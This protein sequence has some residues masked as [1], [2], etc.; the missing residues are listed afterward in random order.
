[1]VELNLL[2]HRL[3]CY[4]SFYLIP[5]TLFNF[6]LPFLFCFFTSF[7]LMAVVLLFFSARS[8][9]MIFAKVQIARNMK[10]NIIFAALLLARI[11]IIVR[12]NSAIR[13]G[14]G[15]VFVCTV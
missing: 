11:E 1:M 5:R 15:L 7:I 12:R 9:H 6:S 13:I 8:L 10:Y 2:L 14:S 3:V 4:T